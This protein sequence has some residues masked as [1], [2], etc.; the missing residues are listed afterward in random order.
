MK[1]SLPEPLRDQLDARVHRL[2]TYRT[3]SE[4]V[5]EL[6]RRDLQADAI[7]Q[8][9]Q[10]L[11]DGINSGHAEPMTAAWRKARRAAL[12]KV[13]PT[14]VFEQE[15]SRRLQG[16]LADVK[17]GRVSGPFSTVDELFAHLDRSASAPPP[18]KRTRRR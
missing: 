16:G 6:V 10:H 17:A 7:E 11:L 5:R 4:Y 13:V 12:A 8:V 15:V 1:F 3:S 9:D 2:G 14:E 18:R